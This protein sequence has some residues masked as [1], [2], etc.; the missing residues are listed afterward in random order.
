VLTWLCWAW[1]TAEVKAS[2]VLLRRWFSRVSQLT[3][4]RA[5]VSCNQANSKPQAR[6]DG[7][8]AHTVSLCHCVTV[9]LWILTCFVTAQ[10]AGLGNWSE[11]NAEGQ[12]E[13]QQMVHERNEK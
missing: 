13:Q 1:L 10:G 6:E 5:A 9:S 7:R 4:C 11:C 3:V 8:Y 2:T 12:H